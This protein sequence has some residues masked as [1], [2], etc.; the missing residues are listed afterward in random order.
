[1]N[2]CIRM[3]FIKN[4]QLNNCLTLQLPEVA[5]T[6]E[7]NKGLTKKKRKNLG[8]WDICRELYKVLTY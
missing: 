3:A 5:L 1:M 6:V 4:N 2:N 8:K 7:A